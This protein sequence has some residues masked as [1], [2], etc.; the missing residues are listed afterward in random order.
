MPMILVEFLTVSVCQTVPKESS[1]GS[2]FQST[3]QE[4]SKDAEVFPYKSRREGAALG[5]I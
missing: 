1:Q 4:T 5:W 3:S 2:K